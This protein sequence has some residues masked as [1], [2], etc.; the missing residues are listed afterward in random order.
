L[1]PVISTGGRN[2]LFDV[3][4]RVG[5]GHHQ[6]AQPIL[7]LVV[8]RIKRQPNHPA[9]TLV[10]PLGEQGGL[11]IACWGRE[12]NQFVMRDTALK[13]V[14]EVTSQHRAQREK[15]RVQRRNEVY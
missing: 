12:Q 6:Q 2:L 9:A 13:E 7:G 1:A 14:D 11:A 10:C 4:L 3:R 15:A 8:I 5:P